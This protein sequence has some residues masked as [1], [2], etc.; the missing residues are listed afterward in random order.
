MNIHE[1]TQKRVNVAKTYLEDGAFYTA[2][3]VFAELAEQIEAHMDE[4]QK[5]GFEPEIEE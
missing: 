5:W 1:H 2:A 4:V 3:S